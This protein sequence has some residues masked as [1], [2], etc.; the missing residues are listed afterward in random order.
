MSLRWC[1]SPGNATRMAALANRD[2]RMSTYD[3]GLWTDPFDATGRPEARRRYAVHRWRPGYN[4][5]LRDDRLARAN[6]EVEASGVNSLV[7]VEGRHANGQLR[8]AWRSA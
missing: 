8:P 2:Y 7:E 5:C 3:K 6:Q 4:P 1:E